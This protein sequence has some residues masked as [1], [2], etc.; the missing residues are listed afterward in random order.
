MDKFIPDKNYIAIKTLC[1]PIST[2]L[3]LCYPSIKFVYV[4]NLKGLMYLVL[5]D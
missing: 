5:L 3:R 2:G 4:M 1:A